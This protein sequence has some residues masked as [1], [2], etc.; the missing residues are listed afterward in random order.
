MTE[1]GDSI[2]VKCVPNILTD[3]TAAPEVLDADYL[4]LVEKQEESSYSQVERELG[5][6]MAWKKQVL[7]FIVL[8][9]DAVP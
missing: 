4:V 2:T 6:L 3:P 1:W 8:D 9:V 7:G 5:E